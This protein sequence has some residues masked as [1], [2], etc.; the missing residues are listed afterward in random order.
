MSCSGLAIAHLT[1]PFTST[2]AALCARAASHASSA[3]IAMRRAASPP[4][5]PPS[6]SRAAAR[7]ALCAAAPASKHSAS[8]AASAA[9]CQGPLRRRLAGSGAKPRVARQRLLDS[10][11]LQ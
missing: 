7:T 6:A 10:Q 3:F 1:I 8:S 11:L 4:A 2:P 5:P 9:R